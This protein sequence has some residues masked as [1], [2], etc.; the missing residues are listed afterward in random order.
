ME[1]K[2]E[3]S[4]F[5]DQ[6]YSSWHR[7]LGYNCAA[8]DIDQVV[9]RDGSTMEETSTLWNEYDLKVPVALVETKVRNYGDVD[10]TNDSNMV[11]NSK[12]ADMASLPFFVVKHNSDLSEFHIFAYNYHA[13]EKLKEIAGNSQISTEKWHKRTQKQYADFLYRLRNRKAPEAILAG[14]QG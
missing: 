14:L 6:S 9:T 7:T 13:K 10:L 11:A 1:V 4:H 12:L 2:A 3:R 8:T 5:R